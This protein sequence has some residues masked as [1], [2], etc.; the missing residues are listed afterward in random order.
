MHRQQ[1]CAH[2]TVSEVFLLYVTVHTWAKYGISYRSANLSVVVTKIMIF[3]CVEVVVNHFS[4]NY[5]KNTMF[6]LTGTTK[7]TL[8]K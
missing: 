5:W 2:E 1:S 7:H 3:S 8:V 4:K 6:C